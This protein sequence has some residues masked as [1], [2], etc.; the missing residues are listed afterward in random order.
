LPKRPPQFRPA[1]YR[2][3]AA[4]VADP[5][6]AST[7][8]RE[9]RAKRLAMDNHTCVVEGCGQRAIVA[10]HIVSR[11]AGGADSITNLRSLCHCYRFALPCGRQ[12]VCRFRCRNFQ[13]ACGREA[14]EHQTADAGSFAEAAAC[15]SAAMVA[16]RNS[17]SHFVEWNGKPV[18]SVKTG[19]GSA[20]RIAGLDVTVG[21]VYAA[22]PATYGGYVA[23]A[24]WCSYVG[25]SGLFGHERKDPA[26]YLWPP[27]PGPFARRSRCHRVAAHPEEG[28]VGCFV[29]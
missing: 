25:S 5:Y 10:D 23:D 21:N 4:K 12:I 17:K 9:L 24:A 7:P 18:S 14:G 28:S 13:P 8:W 3:P 26:R 15:P 29:G 6:Y 11:S 20:V 22:H 16:A 1:T 2:P 19:F 27:P